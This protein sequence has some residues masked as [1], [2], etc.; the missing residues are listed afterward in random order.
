MNEAARDELILK[1]KNRVDLFCEALKGNNNIYLSSQYA[2]L[3]KYLYE[4]VEM[5]GQSF[6]KE[7]FE[8][9]RIQVKLSDVVASLSPGDR[10]MLCVRMK[11]N[12]WRASKFYGNDE[13]LEDI[14]IDIIGD[15]LEELDAFNSDGVDWLRDE[16][17]EQF[18]ME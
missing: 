17:L 6:I 1:F 12:K 2:M 9:D 10:C 5:S 16:L 3:T 14:L 13:E 11:D 4:L 8:A 18:N 15:T 7:H